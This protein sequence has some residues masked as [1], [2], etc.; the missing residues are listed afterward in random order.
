MMIKL[1]HITILITLEKKII[2]KDVHFD[3]G[4]V[5]ILIQTHSPS[6][7]DDILRIFLHKNSTSPNIHSLPCPDPSR[8]ITPT[9]SPKQVQTTSSPFQPSSPN[10][11]PLAN[12]APLG[13]TI[14]LEPPLDSQLLPQLP[15][16]SS[17]FKQ[18]NIKL[19]DYILSITPEDFDICTVEQLTEDLTDDITFDEVIKHPGWTQAMQDEIDSIKCN[20]TWELPPLPP[21]RKTI[22]AKWVFK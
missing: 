21:G 6:D 5:G 19:N 13:S 22:S 9:T 20:E 7:D 15:R 10:F 8:P 17:R 18:Q 3:E 4:I 16:R 1:K 12:P 14:S 2:S 11:S